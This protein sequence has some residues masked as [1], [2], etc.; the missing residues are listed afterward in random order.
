MLR[1]ALTGMLLFVVFFYRINYQYLLIVIALALLIAAKT[2]YKS[3]RIIALG[4]AIFPAGWLWMINVA[5]WFVY[6]TPRNEWVAPVLEKLGLT[7]QDIP[8]LAYV[9]FTCALTV[10]MII[11]IIQA[12]FRWR[13]PLTG[14][15][16]LTLRFTDQGNTD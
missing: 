12:L 3:E 2:T 14:Q 6:L 10:L 9:V 1:G 15:N 4:L 7:H 5:T 11:Y 16:T 13:Q 8:D